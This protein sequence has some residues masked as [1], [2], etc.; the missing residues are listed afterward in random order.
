[1]TFQ[2]SDTVRFH[3]KVFGS[4]WAPYYDAYKG[5]TFMVVGFYEGRHVGLVCLDDPNV[6]VNG[7]VHE[8]ELVKI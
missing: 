1:M 8:D 3:T 7:H 4:P 2:L 5:H 6:K